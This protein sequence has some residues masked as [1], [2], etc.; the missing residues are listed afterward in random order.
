MSDTLNDFVHRATMAIIEAEPGR[1]YGRTELTVRECVEN[2]LLN[3]YDFLRLPPNWRLVRSDHGANTGVVW[4]LEQQV[5]TYRDYDNENS[6]NQIYPT[7]E[8][9]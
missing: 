7:K 4:K 5:V 1:D 9:H 3:Q 8:P 6:P 2:I